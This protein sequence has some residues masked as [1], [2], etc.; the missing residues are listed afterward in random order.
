ME[1]IPRYKGKSNIVTIIVYFS[2]L[3]FCSY[4]LCELFTNRYSTYFELRLNE[5]SFPKLSICISL[6]D[7]KIPNICSYKV[8]SAQ[9]TNEKFSVLNLNACLNY[10]KLVQFYLNESI[11]K[12]PEMIIN[13]AEEYELNRAFTLDAYDYKFDSYSLNSGHL[14]LKFKF[15]NSTGFSIYNNYKYF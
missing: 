9:K 8:A 5:P 3:Y 13:K 2:C 1:S 11:T 14:C 6:E 10:S 4:Y 7:P 12:N 15:I